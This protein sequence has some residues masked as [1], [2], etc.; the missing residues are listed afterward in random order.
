MNFLTQAIAVLVSVMLLNPLCC[1]PAQDSESQATSACCAQQN[2][3]PI[4]PAGEN[5]DCP[6]Q[7]GNQLAFNHE[8]KQTHQLLHFISVDTCIDV[9]VSSGFAASDH[10]GPATV[11]ILQPIVPNSGPLWLKHCTLLI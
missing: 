9:E 2:S 11:S 1:C 3:V 5:H 7:D 6:H 10:A 4:E 8:A